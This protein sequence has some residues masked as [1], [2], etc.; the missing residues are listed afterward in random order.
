MDQ[1][2]D[3]SKPASTSYR[4]TFRRHR[5][6]FCLP[7]ILGAFA[8]A[9]FLLG[10]G[11]TYKS[12]ASLW[13][14]TAP[15]MPSSLSAASGPLTQPPAS[16]EQGILSEL[17]TTA[18]FD[19]AVAAH[20]LIG[21]SLRSA[22]AIRA[23]AAELLANGQVGQTVSGGQVLQISYSASS[24]ALAES[25]L[26]A[27][28]AQLSIYTDSLTAQHAQ[29]AV[30][31]DRD[32]VKVA[33]SALAMA[34]ANVTAYQA[35]HPQVT[36]R[37]TNYAALLSTQNNAA[38]QL[39]R[40]NTALSQAADT[41]TGNGVWS[42]RVV[43]PPAQATTTPL[44]KKKIAE[45]ILGG[46][47]GGLLVSFLAVVALTPAKKEVWEDELPI[48]EPF[49]PDMPSAEPSPAESPSVA[50]APRPST[51]AP[52]AVRPRLVVGE[53]RFQFRAPSAHIEEQ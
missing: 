43:D 38:T 53:R 14:D 3:K 13:V 35:Q 34:R 31:Y 51:P 47:L 5:K 28:I 11:R 12:T 49:F 16:A 26:R 39:A 42:I 50:T 44:G 4:E 19:S 30:A 18:S 36:P 46:A 40:A 7:I 23:K 1:S 2:L 29:A 6:L 52:T 10:T 24:P 22:D 41:G 37:D 45:V 21:K 27:L 48:G 32:Q 9:F 15:T 8:A 20:S 33:Q 17:L 25:V